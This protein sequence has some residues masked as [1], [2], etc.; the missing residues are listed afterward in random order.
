MFNDPGS[1][2]GLHIIIPHLRPAMPVTDWESNL[3]EMLDIL[4]GIRNKGFIF[5][6]SKYTDC[7]AIAQPQVS[8]KPLRYFV[9]NDGKEFQNMVKNFGGLVVINPVL[10]SRLGSS[11]IFFKDACMSYP[12]APAVKVKRYEN[13][14]VSYDTIK[15]I[16]GGLLASPKLVQVRNKQLLGLD[17][18]V[19]Q[20]ELEHLNGKSIYALA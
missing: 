13:I 10:E 1:P 8:D 6:G 11:K 4:A 19:F 2:N 7:F 9:L 12:Y 16:E 3:P 18:L 5:P 17:A 15:H 20:H 14:T